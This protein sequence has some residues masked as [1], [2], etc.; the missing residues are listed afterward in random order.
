VLLFSVA[1]WLV[2]AVVYATLLFVQSRGA[3]R[4]LLSLRVGVENMVVPASLG[5][6]V[7]WLVDR[8]RWPEAR[9]A[10]FFTVHA[11]LALVF[12]GLSSGWVFLTASGFGAG[13]MSRAAVLYG[14][15][16]WHA[17]M[18]AMLYGLIAS[19]AY[20]AR[21]ALRERD[22]H[23]AAERA[24][25]LRA[26]ADLAALRAHI[27]PHFLFN[28]LHSV[29]ELLRTDAS[30]AEEA[31]ERLS[32]LFRYTLK[33]DR[34]RVDVVP[35]DDEWKFTAGY[36]WLER[37][38]MGPRLRI[39]AEFD[40]SALSYVVPPFT[41]Q[42]IVENAIRHGIGPKPAGGTVVVRAREVRDEL[43]ITVRDDGVG[44]TDGENASGGLGLRSVR[45]RLEARHGRA[46]SVEAAA[47]PAGFAV[48][49]RLPAEM[50]A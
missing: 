29:C 43:V 41:L 30:S 48:T 23:I 40:E 4:P 36:L 6:G 16:P 9:P 42:P 46:A 24:E 26:E 31:I 5:V 8:V 35:L 14:A 12:A 22:L 28:T 47:S 25:R 11:G 7:W 10:R 18:G 50:P 13:G 19:A 27:D 37:L 45:Q 32:D 38:R 34:Q 20:T 21:A 33:L 49:I 3:M 1:G 17:V 44:S 39:D 2:F 15:L